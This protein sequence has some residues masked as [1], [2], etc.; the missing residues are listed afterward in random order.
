MIIFQVNEEQGPRLSTIVQ[1]HFESVLI[2]R[3]KKKTPL[4][5]CQSI[6]SATRSVVSEIL[7]DKHL[8]PNEKMPTI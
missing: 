6:V 5:H 1:N 4:H 3:G 7:S 8:S 2:L